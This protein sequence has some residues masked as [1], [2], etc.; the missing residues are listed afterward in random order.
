MQ[1]RTGWLWVNA[2]VCSCPADLQLVNTC[3][4]ANWW[5]LPIFCEQCLLIQRSRHLPWERWRIARELTRAATKFVNI[6]KTAVKLGPHLG[7]SLLL[8]SSTP[9]GR[10]V[11]QV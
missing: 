6:D 4:L 2:A 1:L 10:C 8:G 11:L 9:A 5:R 3:L 7:S